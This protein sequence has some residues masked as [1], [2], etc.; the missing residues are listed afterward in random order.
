MKKV[1][2]SKK[3]IAI[4]C[5]FVLALTVVVISTVPARTQDNSGKTPAGVPSARQGGVELPPPALVKHVLNGTFY[6]GTANISASCSSS[7][8][9]AT[10]VPIFSESIICPGA[11]GA[12]CTYEV[13]IA[14]QTN[15]SGPG[16]NGLYQFLVD[17]A[18]PT[19]GGTDSSGLYAWELTGAGGTYTSAYEVVSSVK[20]TVANQAHSIDVNITCQDITFSGSCTAVQGFADLIVRVLKP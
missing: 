7:N 13:N 12:K 14:G 16:N 6:D 8:C 1:Q 10:P 17:G 20:N 18:I 19:G 5:M 3:A 15:V 4:A 9:L 2:L 11:I